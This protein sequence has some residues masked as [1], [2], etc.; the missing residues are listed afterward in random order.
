MLD[1]FA[2][3]V[4]NEE[5]DKGEKGEEDQQISLIAGEVPVRTPAVEG[6]LRRTTRRTHR[7][8]KRVDR[9]SRTHVVDLTGMRLEP[10]PGGGAAQSVGDAPS[11]A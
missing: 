1:A 9:G 11:S 2:S 7:G 5:P 4:L 3:A 10:V 8:P 6:E